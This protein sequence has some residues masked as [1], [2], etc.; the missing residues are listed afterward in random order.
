MSKHTLSVLVEDKPGVLARIAGLFSRRGFNIDSLAVGPTEHS[1]ISRM[2]VVVDVEELPLEQVTKQL[3]KLVEVLKVV[4]LDPSA[5]VQRQVML[6]KVR[7]DAT[8]R[9]S[10]LETVQM[11]RAKVVDVAHDCADHRGHRQG[12]EAPGPA[13]RPR[14]LRRPGARP[15]G[16]RRRRPRPAVDHRPEPAQRLSTAR[17]AETDPHTD[18]PAY[19]KRLSPPTTKE[20]ATMAE[21]FYDDDADLAVIQGRKVAVIGYGSQGHAHALN[22]RDSGVDVR[23]G[24]AEG[25]RVP[26]QG[27]G[28]G[29]ARESVAD[30]VKEADLVVILTPDQV[31]RTSTPTTSSR[32]SRRAPRCSSGTASTSASA[33]S[34]PRPAPT[35]LMVAPKGPGHLVRREFVDGRGVPVLLA[36]EQDAVR[37]GLGPR[38]VV[39]QGHRRPAGRRHQ[40]DVHRGD[41][42]RP[43]R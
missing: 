10:I 21:M 35:S 24:L 26:G 30:A 40:D 13:R 2:T 7:A 43:V 37:R 23:V 38:A 8:T 25:S 17:R 20:M 15:V 9:S 32:T 12:R 36:V 18:P 42:D 34:S 4:E 5:S 31:Q 11:F 29:P 6:I 16:H 1:D 19:R 39:R 28:R 22:L 14:A 33:T 41:R 27:G 3:N